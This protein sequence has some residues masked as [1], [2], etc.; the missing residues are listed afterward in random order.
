[1]E[2]LYVVFFEI[3]ISSPDFIIEFIVSS[4]VDH[5]TA[6]HPSFSGKVTGKI[7]MLQILQLRN[8]QQEKV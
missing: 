1:M 6:L 3:E 5:P 7:R 2:V 8:M 4:D